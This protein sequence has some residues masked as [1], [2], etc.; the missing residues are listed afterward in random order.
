MLDMVCIFAAACDL[1]ISA[2][3]FRSASS[4]S[5]PGML[6]SL[7]GIYNRAVAAASKSPEAEGLL[8]LLGFQLARLT[9]SLV[10]STVLCV[11]HVALHSTVAA[12]M[13]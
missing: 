10:R 5:G 1:G 12:G 9:T 8:A 4:S 13:C 7:C 2:V 11:E 3:S 6:T